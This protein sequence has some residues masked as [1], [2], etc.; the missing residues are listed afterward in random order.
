MNYLEGLGFT[1]DQITEVN[2]KNDEF[3]INK[4]NVK[5][6]LIQM[7]LTFLRDL[8][9]TNFKEIFV[10]Y[11]EFFLQEPTIFK[12]IFLK[13]DREDLIEKLL[14]NPAIIVRL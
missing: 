9:V 12:N 1:Q 4:L 7:N 3:I 6:K 2:N 10:D 8:G 14:K 13:Y 5:Q 11:S